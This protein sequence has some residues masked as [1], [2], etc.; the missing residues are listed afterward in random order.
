MQQRLQYIWHSKRLVCYGV[1]TIIFD[2][3]KLSHRAH[4]ISPMGLE[5]STH[6]HTHTHIK[7]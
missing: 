7:C 5:H 3:A 1:Q 2:G 4:F 6:T